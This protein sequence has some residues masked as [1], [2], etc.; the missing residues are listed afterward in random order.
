MNTLKEEVI[1]E[2]RRFGADW[3]AELEE[4]AA[5]LHQQGFI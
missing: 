3:Y 1:R 5:A 4:V 2:F